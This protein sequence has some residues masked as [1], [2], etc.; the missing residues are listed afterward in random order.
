MT[1]LQIAL[2]SEALRD[3]EIELEKREQDLVVREIEIEYRRKLCLLDSD[4]RA[5]T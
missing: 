4:Q 5:S 2:K 1:R 3:R